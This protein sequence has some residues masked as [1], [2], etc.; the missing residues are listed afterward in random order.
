MV[1]CLK[2]ANKWPQKSQT[3]YTH[4]LIKA[5][6]QVFLTPTPR[7]LCGPQAF[8]VPF[9]NWINQ[10]CSATFPAEMHLVV[11]VRSTGLAL[12]GETFWGA[13]NG[14]G[15]CFRHS[16]LIALLSIGWH[17]LVMLSLILLFLYSGHITPFLFFFNLLGHSLLNLSVL[18]LRHIQNLTTSYFCCYHHSL[19]HHLLSKRLQ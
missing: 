14:P 19:E 12:M 2:L 11:I 15:Q 5:E 17:T 3:F 16:Q 8:S 18:S 1:L 13:R 6:P 4:S 7:L 9:R 10:S